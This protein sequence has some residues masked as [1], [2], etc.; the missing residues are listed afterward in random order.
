[1]PRHEAVERHLRGRI[2]GLEPGDQLESEAELCELFHV[3]RMTVRQAMNRLVSE[4]AIYRI[5]GVGTFV[6]HS[7]VHREMGRL[8]SFTAEMTQRGMKASSRILSMGIREASGDEVAALRLA[9]RSNVL[10]IHRLRLAD[11]EPM[12]IETTALTPDLAWVEHEDLSSGS[13]HATLSAHGVRPARATGTQRAELATDRDG[14]LLEL[15]L[16]SA[17]FVEQ[18]LIY[19]EGGSPV[20]ATETRYAGNR[21]VFH[22]ELFT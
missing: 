8:R 18:R 12:A 21:F 20:E 14:A 17:L 2:A 19:D 13:L 11:N 7:E 4:G 3:S 1:M 16:P 9:P 6:G 5:S 22:I 15:E 10:A